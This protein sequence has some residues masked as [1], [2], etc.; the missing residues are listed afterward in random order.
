MALKV[1]VAAK[2]HLCQTPEATVKITLGSAH[3]VCRCELRESAWP[4]PR[5]P[6]AT[7]RLGRRGRLERGPCPHTLGRAGLAAAFCTFHSGIHRDSCQQREVIWGHAGFCEALEFRKSVARVIR[8]QTGHRW[9]YNYREAS[10][11]GAGRPV[12]R[13]RL[14]SRCGPAHPPRGPTRPRR[15]QPVI[16]LKK[17]GSAA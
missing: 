9:E 3:S 5:G 8:S 10:V 14:V 4:E 12:Q 1:A 15:A 17:L 2:G 6:L 13:N 11:A 16:V 7:R